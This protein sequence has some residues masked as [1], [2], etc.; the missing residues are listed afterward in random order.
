M[1]PAACCCQAAW[2][3]AWHYL[4]AVWQQGETTG[5]HGSNMASGRSLIYS[6]LTRVL[7][8]AARLLAVGVDWS[9]Q[10]GLAS[11]CAVL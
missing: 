2:C 1:P 7:A 11:L 9:L 5:T 8:C 6:S 10:C 3:P 4:G